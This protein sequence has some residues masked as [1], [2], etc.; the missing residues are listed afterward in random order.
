LRTQI[1]RAKEPNKNEKIDSFPGALGY[2]IN[3]R[4]MPTTVS[5]II[6]KNKTM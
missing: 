1:Q 5:Q 3:N 2:E 6:T 4:N